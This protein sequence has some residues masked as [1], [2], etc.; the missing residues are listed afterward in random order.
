LAERCPA[1]APPAGAPACLL[2]CQAGCQ[3]SLAGGSPATGFEVLGQVWASSWRRRRER[4]AVLG[5]TEG[6]I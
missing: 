2:L 1:R 6:W 5:G 4:E 3:R